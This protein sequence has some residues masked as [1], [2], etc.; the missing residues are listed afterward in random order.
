MNVKWITLD[1]SEG[2]ATLKQHAVIPVMCQERYLDK[3]YPGNKILCNKLFA[4]EDG[5][6]AQDWDTIENEPLGENVCK[7]CLEFSQK[8]SQIRK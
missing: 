8:V 5:E 7:K 4:S 1:N 6:T 2:T 3:K